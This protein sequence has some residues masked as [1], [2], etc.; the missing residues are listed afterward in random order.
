MNLVGE[1]QKKYDAVSQDC[2]FH[3]ANCSSCG[4][5]SGRGRSRPPI[6]RLCIG[7]DS[8]VELSGL[9]S[10]QTTDFTTELPCGVKVYVQINAIM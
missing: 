1:R 2:F 5:M 6:D 8:S 3:I 10:V 4:I 9:F 7:A